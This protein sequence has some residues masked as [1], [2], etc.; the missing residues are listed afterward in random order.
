MYNNILFFGGLRINTDIDNNVKV[1][2]ANR[3]MFGLL[4][5]IFAIIKLL[6]VTTVYCMERDN[7]E[8]KLEQD[9]LME[10]SQQSLE[11]RIQNFI[12]NSTEQ[13]RQDM[14]LALSERANDIVN[15]VD[16]TWNLNW[17]ER[18]LIIAGIGIL[19]YFIYKYSGDI[20]N[21]LSHH[22]SEMNLAQLRAT[23]SNVLIRIARGSIR[24]NQVVSDVLSSF[25]NQNPA[26]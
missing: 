1:K 13:Q 17:Y 10:V 12:A 20:L 3:D 8:Y 25:N 24:G 18:I 2:I 19:M 16:D 7:P 11:R 5:V 15:D 9:L 4:S 26:A 6:S 21:S 22:A 14:A 23:S